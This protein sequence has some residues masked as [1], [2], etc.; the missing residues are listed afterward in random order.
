MASLPDLEVEFFS[1]R[2][3]FCLDQSC[4]NNLVSVVDESLVRYV[5]Y[6]IKLEFMC[7]WMGRYPRYALN[8]IF[9]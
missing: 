6:D 9:D 5:A 4:R 8:S 3:K 1:R 2:L 7:L